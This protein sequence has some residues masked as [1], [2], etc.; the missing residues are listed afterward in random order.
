MATSSPF[1]LVCSETIFSYLQTAY[2]LEVYINNVSK[3]YFLSL[4]RRNQSGHSYNFFFPCIVGRALEQRLPALLEVAGKLHSELDSKIVLPS[5]SVLSENI[6]TKGEK[7]YYLGLNYEAEFKRYVVYLECLSC[8]PDSPWIAKVR[9]FNLSLA[10]TRCLVTKL[11]FAVRY[12][13]HL[14]SE[15]DKWPTIPL[16]PPE[17][18]DDS[19]DG[20]IDGARTTALQAATSSPGYGIGRVQLGH[21]DEF[22]GAGTNHSGDRDGEPAP[23]QHRTAKRTRKR[24]TKGKAARKRAASKRSTKGKAPRKRAASKKSTK[25]STKGTNNQDS[26]AKGNRSRRARKVRKVVAKR[27]FVSNGY[28]SE[29]QDE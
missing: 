13:E 22:D 29:V 6:L 9:A 12:A 20:L 16:E 17:K 11:P 1:K 2:T 19:T 10:A 14:Q 3:C 15:V 24:A 7:K 5:R 8:Q 25:D 27:S 23:E 28:D 21:A 4:G 18:S 26:T